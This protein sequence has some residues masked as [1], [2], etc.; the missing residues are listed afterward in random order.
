MYALIKEGVTSPCLE[1]GA[2]GEEGGDIE[3]AIV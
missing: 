3:Q 1:D 2:S